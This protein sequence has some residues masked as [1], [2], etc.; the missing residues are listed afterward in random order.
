MTL[1]LPRH[2]L[3]LTGSPGAGK[4]TVAKSLATFSECPAVH[5]HADDFWRFIVK[6]VILPYLP[7][8]RRQNEVGV[9]PQRRTTALSTSRTPMEPTKRDASSNS[10]T[11]AVCDWCIACMTV[12]SGVPAR[13]Q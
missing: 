7:A 4:T 5:L 8:A 6:G 13:A 9:Q 10:A 12:L 1:N 11:G 3:I 2:I